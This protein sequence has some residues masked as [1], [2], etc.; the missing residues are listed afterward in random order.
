MNINIILFWSLPVFLFHGIRQ[1]LPT[2]LPTEKVMGHAA[3]YL[4]INGIVHVCVLRE[5]MLGFGFCI[6]GFDKHIHWGCI[7]SIKNHATTVVLRWVRMLKSS[8]ELTI[9][10]SYQYRVCLHLKVSMVNSEM[11]FAICINNAFSC[12]LPDR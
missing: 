1:W 12:H 2:Y 7:V 6:L 8:L 4:Q 9:M 10:F 11:Y 5:L 3:V